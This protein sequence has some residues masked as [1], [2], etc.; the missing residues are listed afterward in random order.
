MYSSPQT[1]HMTMTP[2]RRLSLAVIVSAILLFLIA[3]SAH[4][5]TAVY[6]GSGLALSPISGMSTSVDVTSVIVKIINFILNLVLII[7]VLAVIVAGFYLITSNGDE[8]QKD[9][10]KTIILYVAIGI[11]VILFA[12]LIVLFVNNLV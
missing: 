4:A 9:K 8:G 2:L 10:A 3:E 6:S 12:K 11:I 5:Y 7:A 1:M